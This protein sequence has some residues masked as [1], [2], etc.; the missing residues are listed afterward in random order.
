VV[1]FIISGLVKHFSK[2]K[3]KGVT[4][5]SSDRKLAEQLVVN[6][7]Y[8]KFEILHL[9]FVLLFCHYQAKYEISKEPIII[10]ESLN[11]RNS[12]KTISN[13]SQFTYL[14]IR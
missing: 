10:S 14:H 7:I 4:V 2:K 11:S 13:I 1:D 3:K 8:T 6:T 9:K 12:N 5:K